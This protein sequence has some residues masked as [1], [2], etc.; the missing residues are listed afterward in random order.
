MVRA[1]S[2]ECGQCHQ[3]IISGESFV[4]FKIPG[5]ETYQFFHCRFRIGDCWEGYLEKG[6]KGIGASARVPYCA[7]TNDVTFETTPIFQEE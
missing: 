1:T 7:G 5:K 4:S 2:V 3:L 6:S